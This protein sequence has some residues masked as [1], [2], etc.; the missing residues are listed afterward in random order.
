MRSP[1][2]L[3]LGTTNCPMLWYEPRAKFTSEERRTGPKG[4][5]SWLVFI[6]T[7]ILPVKMW[8]VK[9]ILLTNCQYVV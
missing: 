8:T 6:L 2:M 1:E 3:G 4:F 5:S 7:E 9:E